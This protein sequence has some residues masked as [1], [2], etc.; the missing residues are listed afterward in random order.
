[1]DYKRIRYEKLEGNLAK[2][3]MIRPDFRNAEDPLMLGEMQDAFVE[4]DI[5]EDVR[6]IIFAGEGKDF[7]AGHDMSGT[8]E[9]APDGT[10]MRRYLDTKLTGVEMRLRR[11]DW[12]YRNQAYVMRNV[13]KPTIAM[14]Q[15]HCI[16]GGWINASMCDL[17]VASE[18]ASFGDPVIRQTNGA[19][20]I[21][22]HPYEVGFRR[23]KYMLWTGETISA[24]DAYNVG[25]VCKVVPRTN[26][27]EETMALAK[28]I[29]MN[30]PVAVS[31]IKRS[32]NFAAE[33]MGQKL[34]W[35]YHF[36]LHEMAHATDEATEYNKI[37]AE[38]MKKGGLA[39]ALKLRDNMF[40][41][42]GS[43]Y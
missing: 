8:G 34:A 28:R 18:D 14:V 37:R 40:K 9:K 32:V 17:I 16:A 35:E 24:Q 1:M 39:E 43:K 6:V 23:A 15:G 30:F 3:T 22:F 2:V 31:F 5:D 36:L 25:M 38:A 4:A 42:A 33:A 41:A 20:E 27:E 7:S 11:E 26:L 29:A 10:L 12:L 19:V 13:S 21:L